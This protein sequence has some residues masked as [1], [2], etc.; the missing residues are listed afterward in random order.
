MLAPTPALPE[1]PPSERGRLRQE[2]DFYR[3]LLDLGAK[4]EIEP[5]LDECLAQIAKIAGARRGYLELREDGA[6][7]EEPRFWTAHGCYDDEIDEIRKAF[8]SGVIAAALA[9]GQTIITESALKD[10]RFGTRGSVRRNQTEAVLCAPIGD[11]PPFGVIYLQDRIAPGPFCEE[12]RHRAE[13]FARHIA[14]YADRLLIRRRRREE[15]DMTLESRSKLR[16]DGIIGRSVAMGR[17]L[18]Q[19]AV[20]APLEVAILLT[21]PSGSGKTQLARLLHSNS[22]RSAGPFVELNCAALP[23]SLLESE[24]F[25]ALPGA[26]S[27]ASKRLIGKVAAAERGTLFLDEIFELKLAAQAKLLQLLESKEYFPLGSAKPFRADVR[28]IAATNADL[29]D[30]VS[31][32]EFREDLYYR[33]HVL[34]IRVPSLAERREDIRP[35]A[36]HFCS[37]AVHTHHLP[38]IQLSA[39]ALRAAETAEWAG[40]VRELLHA[41]EA[42]V[43][44]AAGEGSLQVE[45]R[46][47]FPG[48]EQVD[49][50]RRTFQ[51]AT[52]RYQEQLVRQAVEETSWNVTEAA[53]RLGLTRAHLYNLIRA[54]GLERPR[55]ALR[56]R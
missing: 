27:T 52:R 40:N 2:R 29:R 17:M 7:S 18:Q 1:E 51:E 43:I 35:L 12:D 37:R 25:G 23:E 38:Q 34:P 26:H 28:V 36:E 50:A 14:P 53:A 33:L 46:H 30:A 55:S 32:K 24:L 41:L 9:T 21:G 54:F 20:A 4:N 11:D 15:A 6:S 10:P 42:A 56:E 39:D 8:S 19:V 47:L 44:R 5:F 48:A 16:A 31:R 45:R 13:M 49:G 3:S 22:P